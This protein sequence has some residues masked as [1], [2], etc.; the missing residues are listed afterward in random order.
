[1]ERV[2]VAQ[3]LALGVN[4]YVVQVVRYRPRTTVSPSLSGLDR[5]KL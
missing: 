2:D 3:P 1:V 4:Q 5:R